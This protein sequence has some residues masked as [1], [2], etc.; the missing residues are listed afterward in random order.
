MSY[1]LMVSLDSAFLRHMGRRWSLS[2]AAQPEQTH[3]WPQAA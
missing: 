1:T 2:I 3:M